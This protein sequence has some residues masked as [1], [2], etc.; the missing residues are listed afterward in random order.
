MLI[1]GQFSVFTIIIFIIEMVQFFF[2]S[3]IQPINK[4][5]LLTITLQVPLS[6]V[7]INTPANF[8]PVQLIRIVPMISLKSML[9]W[10]IVSFGRPFTLCLRNLATRR[11]SDVLVRIGDL[12]RE[13]IPKISHKLISSIN[14]EGRRSFRSIH[15]N[16]YNWE[17]KQNLINKFSSACIGT[18]LISHLARTRPLLVRTEEFKVKLTLGKII[19]FS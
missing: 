16:N 17:G 3:F 8:E 18:G 6:H 5:V 11:I 19:F 10:Y 12:L 7:K 13:V 2:S 9:R 15:L 1:K 4:T 14:V